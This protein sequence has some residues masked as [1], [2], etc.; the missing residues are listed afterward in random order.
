[1]RVWG[2]FVPASESD[3]QWQKVRELRAAGD[4]VVM[5]L[6]GQEKPLD[7]QSCDR[8]L[9]ENGETFVVESL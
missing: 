4:R 7:H 8:V 3:K 5:A 2:I 6:S 9:I 1:M